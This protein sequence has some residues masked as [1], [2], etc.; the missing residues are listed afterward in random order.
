MISA[1]KLSA[2]QLPNPGPLISPAGDDLSALRLPAI[3]ISI[4]KY[5]HFGYPLSAL[6]LPGGPIQPLF[7]H[8]IG[9]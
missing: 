4:T 5:R 9:S 6:Q 8:L 1:G 7:K 3:G 2:F